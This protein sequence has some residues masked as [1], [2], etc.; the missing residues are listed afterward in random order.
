MRAWT[1]Q[2]AETRATLLSQIK[3]AEWKNPRLTIHVYRVSVIIHLCHISVI[4]NLSVSCVCD[5][6]SVSCVCDNLLPRLQCACRTQVKRNV[7]CWFPVRNH[8]R[9]RSRKV[10]ALP[11]PS[12][13]VCTLCLQALH[14]LT[15]D[16][17]RSTRRILGGKVPGES[18]EGKHQ[19]NPWGKHQGN[20]WREGARVN[21]SQ[22]REGRK[23]LKDLP[24]L[25]H[26]S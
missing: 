5:N 4:I 20:P 6:E 12:A 1:L 21:L 16:S 10:P 22:G 17:G 13:P 26:S 14:L 24:S 8:L 11:S 7:W 19:G 15:G 23:A 18:L 3:C 25:A 2:S 9:V